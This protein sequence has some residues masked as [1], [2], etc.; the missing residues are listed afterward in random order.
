MS[1]WVFLIRYGHAP[2]AAIIMSRSST[3]T[4]PLPS[5]SDEQYWGHF[6]SPHSIE[7][8]RYEP[9]LAIQAFIF[10]KTQCDP[11][12]NG[13]CV[14]WRKWYVVWNECWVRKVRIL[15]YM[16]SPFTVFPSTTAQT[17]I[18]VITVKKN[19]SSLFH[20]VISFKWL[21]FHGWGSVWQL[22]QLIAWWL[23]TSVVYIRQSNML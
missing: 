3:S 4:E 23:T 12:H 8:P 10:V 21:L 6:A 13:Q 18:A 15:Q 9:S 2:H 17:N 14:G 16:V 20:V 5:R 11:T 22:C 1:L 19:Y 7:S